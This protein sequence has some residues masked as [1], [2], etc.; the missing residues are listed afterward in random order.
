MKW[1]LRSSRHASVFDV[2]RT[3]H[4]QRS[5]VTE[6]RAT[7]DFPLPG[8]VIGEIGVILAVHLAIALAVTLALRAFGI[9]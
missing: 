1:S 8:E 7:S 2:R 3:A 5:L 6:A 4:R 9:A